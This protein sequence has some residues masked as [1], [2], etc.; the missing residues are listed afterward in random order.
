MLDLSILVIE[1]LG[2]HIAEDLW[3][4]HVELFQEL[5]N[6]EVRVTGLGKQG[7]QCLYDISAVVLVG[8]HR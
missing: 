5:H 7:P 4:N 1:L 3:H 6:L 8:S 2:D